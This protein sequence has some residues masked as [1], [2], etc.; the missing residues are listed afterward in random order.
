MVASPRPESPARKKAPDLLITR[1][2]DAP[3]PMV[4]DAWTKP[5]HVA[6]WWGPGG[7][8]LP[9]CHMELR[10]GGV[11]AFTMRAPDRQQYPFDGR[12][13]E[14]APPSRLVFS[15]KVHDDHGDSNDSIVTIA[16]DEEGARTKVALRQTFTFASPATEGSNIGWNQSLDKL[17]GILAATG[18][19][20]IAT[21]SFD[22]P[23]DWVWKAFREPE[24]LSRWW[25]PKGFRNT[26][27]RF[28]FKPGGQWK[29]VMHG[30][31][32]ADYPN[33]A[34]F[35][36]IDEPVKLVLDHVS[37]PKFRLTFTFVDE[38][39]KARVIMHQLFDTPA[40]CDRVRGFAAPANHEN[41]ER[42]GEELKRMR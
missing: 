14:I 19:E 37:R 3:R 7:F 39:G 25:G 27:E 38:G 2:F 13:Q 36:E 26:F 8:D 40:D 15:G 35:V 41:L 32:G 34:V 10:P 4:F 23:V 33:E 9:R 20:L 18:R 24:H 17:T 12:F 5:E 11:F 21:R 30:P 31:N 42:L 16:F 6:R 28:A 22:A 1:V 29:Y